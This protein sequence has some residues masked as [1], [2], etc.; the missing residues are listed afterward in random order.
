VTVVWVFR[1]F[2]WR[3]S[4]IAGAWLI[5]F[6]L[7]WD[8]VM[9]LLGGGG[10]AYWAHIGGFAMGFSLAMLLAATGWVRPAADEQTLL[11]VFGARRSAAG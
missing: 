4:D 10:V 9:L 5:L 1:V 11:E 7:A 2:I 8:V 3:V 6:W